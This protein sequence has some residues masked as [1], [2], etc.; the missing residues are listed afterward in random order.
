MNTSMKTA[1]PD[2]G[3][4]SLY[5]QLL[6][7]K[8]AFIVSSCSKDSSRVTC[9]VAMTCLSVMVLRSELPFVITP[10]SW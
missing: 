4:I 7:P 9:L 8:S 5:S 3:F 6:C 2:L 10:D 1:L